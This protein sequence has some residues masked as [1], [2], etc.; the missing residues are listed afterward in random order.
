MTLELD[1]I[2]PVNTDNSHNNYIIP[3]VE[4]MKGILNY[5]IQLIQKNGESPEIKTI[6]QSLYGYKNRN[7]DTI[8]ANKL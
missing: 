4:R 8:L 1:S 3:D 5:F 7:Y 2:Q 6:A